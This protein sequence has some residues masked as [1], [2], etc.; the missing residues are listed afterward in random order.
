MRKETNNKIAYKGNPILRWKLQLF[1][2]VLLLFC[3]ILPAIAEIRPGDFSVS[4]FIGG[5]LFEGNQDLE[6]RPVYGLRIGYDYS[7]NWGVEAVFDYV[8]TNYKAT[9][10]TTDVFNYRLE[11]LYYI[12]P[13]SKLVPFLAAGIGGMSI[14]SNDDAIDRHRFVLDYGAGLK[15]SLTERWSLRADVRHVLAFGSVYNNLE[16]T[17]GLSFSF[18]GPKARAVSTESTLQSPAAASMVQAPLNLK[19]TAVSNSRIDLGWD[20]VSG[21]MRYKIHRDGS[22]LRTAQTTS[23]AD[24]GLTADTRYCYTVSAIDGTD[25]ESGSSNEACAVALASAAVPAAV[26]EEQKKEAAAA[27]VEKPREL[28]DI[29]FDFDKF[30]LKPAA[31]KI[32][33]RHAQWLNENK[34][35]VL[36]IIIEGHCDERGTADYN[37]ALGERRA[38][39]A[40]KY[41]ISLGIDAGRITTISY[42]FEH[43]LDPGHNKEAWAKNRRAHFVVSERKEPGK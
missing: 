14:D 30:N 16:Y 22:Y 26:M 23:E 11:G 10:S 34:D 5:F 42:G 7:R 2:V 31:R 25:T 40:A 27:I 29:H 39:E 4:P 20:A 33:D 9:D 8:R 32:L 37:M 36:T 28:E 3:T 19:A 15:Y 18:G 17:L 12:L 24:T 21:A 38:E 6:H 43:P 41:L 13:G 1:F 35:V